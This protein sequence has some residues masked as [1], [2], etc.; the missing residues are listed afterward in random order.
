MNLA[1]ALP[2]H[3]HGTRRMAYDSLRGASDKETGQPAAS[4]GSQDNQVGLQQVG[5][6]NDFAIR[7]PRAKVLFDA[8]V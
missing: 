7:S 4:M 8:G 6:V 2:D 5:S 3:Q 1:L